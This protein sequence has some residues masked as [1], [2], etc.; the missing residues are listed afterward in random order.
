MEEEI[1]ESNEWDI[2]NNVNLSPMIISVLEHIKEK[3]YFKSTKIF[4]TYIGILLLHRQ[5]SPQNLI[6]IFNLYP[7]IF[8][9]KFLKYVSNCDKMNPV[10]LPL[11]DEWNLENDIV[12]Y[13]YYSKDSDFPINLNIYQNPFEAVRYLS[14][15]QMTLFYLIQFARVEKLDELIQ[16]KIESSFIAI[17]DKLMYYCSDEN[18]YQLIF[19]CLQLFY[20]HPFI[21]DSFSPFKLKTS[22][23][24]LITKL[25]ITL[26]EYF[27][28]DQKI[29]LT[30]QNYLKPY[31]NTLIKK[32]KKEL[33]KKIKFTEKSFEIIQLFHF[34]IE[35][36]I[37]TLE[38]LINSNNDIL[39]IKEQNIHF[40][41]WADVLFY[42]LNLL[43]DYNEKNTKP[44]TDALIMKM[45]EHYKQLKNFNLNMNRFENLLL[46]YFEI[47]PHQLAH[48]SNGNFKHLFHILTLKVFIAK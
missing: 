36:I 19:E 2:S 8:S 48:K 9:A 38:L 24:E 31:K 18:N 43:N 35:Q 46:K 10:I 16:N 27:K 11:K 4:T 37:D 26:T 20:K 40:S 32:L 22:T 13:F 17:A 41:F 34:D 6:S 12:N 14:I 29:S 5:K 15:F 21:Y 25:F 30:L 45:I 23:N 39:F 33:T 3:E 44:L 42:F 47:F 28:K 1:N 7:K